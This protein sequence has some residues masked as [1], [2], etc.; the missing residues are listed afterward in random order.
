MY[1]KHELRSFSAR[2][3]KR[4]ICNGGFLP[5]E[6]CTLWTFFSTS[7]IWPFSTWWNQLF[8]SY[9]F[10]EIKFFYR[11]KQHHLASAQVHRRCPRRHPTTLPKPPICQKQ[12]PK[13]KQMIWPSVR[14]SRPLSLSSAHPHVRCQFRAQ[15]RPH[16]S[17][18]CHQ[19]SLQSTQ[20]TIRPWAL[21]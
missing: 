3:R 15:F 5:A 18:A 11:K 4:A 10:S 17:K 9:I 2:H 19:F 13:S 21:R 7:L 14:N 6:I 16:S 12:S 8:Y 20:A 1:E